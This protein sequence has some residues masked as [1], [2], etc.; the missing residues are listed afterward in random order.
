MI[1]LIKINLHMRII[2]LEVLD[3][4]N[5]HQANGL[6]QYYFGVSKGVL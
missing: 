3:M 4:L 1:K 5:N 2:K 6:Y